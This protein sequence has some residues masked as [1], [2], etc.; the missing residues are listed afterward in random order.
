MDKTNREIVRRSGRWVRVGVLTLTTVGPIVNTLIEGVRQ[1]SPA[2]REQEQ[3]EAEQPSA[4]DRLEELTLVGR[5][6][7]AEQA[8]QLQIQAQQ[9]QVQARQLREALRDEA[10]QRK[11]VRKLTKQLRNVSADWRE[12]LA[13]RSEYLT[14]GFEGLVE[15]GGKFSQGLRERSGKVAQDLAERSSKVT[16][17][18]TRRGGKLTHDLSERSSEVVQDLAERGLKFTHGLVGQ[19]HDVAHD[20]IEGSEHLFQPKRRRNS[21][22]WTIFGFAVGLVVAGV[23]TYVLVRR[24]VTGQEIEA[25]QHFELPQN[26][27]GDRVGKDRLAGEILYFDQNGAAVATL[28]VVDVEERA[29]PVGAA[30]VGIAS[31]KRYYPVDTPIDRLPLTEDGTKD[32]VYFISEE[33]AKAQGFSPEE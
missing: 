1:R 32:L 33:E 27:Q 23:V 26:D 5:Q 21:T 16:R 6:R 20:L 18:L 14:E 29:Y 30:F 28:Q 22:F 7:A 11:R 31:T 3:L 13:K 2:A 24:R 8:R 15:Q 19:D 17:N 25:E 10:R 12:G 4:F 9:L